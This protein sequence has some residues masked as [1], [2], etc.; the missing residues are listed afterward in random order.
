MRRDLSPAE[1]SCISP[2]HLPCVTYVVGRKNIAYAPAQHD[3]RPTTDAEMRC[4]DMHAEFAAALAAMRRMDNVGSSVRLTDMLARAASRYIASRNQIVTDN[5][6]LVMRKRHGRAHVIDQSPLHYDTMIRCVELFNPYR[7]YRLSTYVV[8]SVQRAE[9]REMTRPA[10]NMETATEMDRMEGHDL[11]AEVAD[12][13]ALAPS[14]F[15]AFNML[16]ERGRYILSHTF[17]VYGSEKRSRNQIAQHFG[18]SGTAVD[19][20]RNCAMR[21]LRELM[22]PPTTQRHMLAVYD[23][24]C[25]RH[26]I[27]P[28]SG[29]SAFADHFRAN[30][31]HMVFHFKSLAQNHGIPHSAFA[32]LLEIEDDPQAAV[33]CEA[34]HED[35]HR[36]ETG[37]HAA[38]GQPKT[39]RK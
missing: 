13:E 18:V 5:I 28:P 26:S 2:E 12:T 11:A 20:W 16:D 9:Y 36:E 10:L 7:G 29:P 14:A 1:R 31:P 35:A 24:W 6:G 30:F 39:K 8:R 15:R 33:E 38:N 21:Q 3:P 27:R 32:A 37:T 22:R 17:G 34:H 4:A 23:E 19:N 25:R